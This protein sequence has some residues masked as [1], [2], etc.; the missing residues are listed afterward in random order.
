MFKTMSENVM[1]KMMD[2]DVDKLSLFPIINAGVVTN[3]SR[4]SR[5]FTLPESESAIPPNY[6]GKCKEDK[7]IEKMCHHESMARISS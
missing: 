5:R 7:N 3:S 2:L 1:C 6:F 4:C